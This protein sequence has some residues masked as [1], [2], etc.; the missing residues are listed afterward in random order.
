MSLRLQAEQV[1]RAPRDAVWAALT[2]V[3]RF[4]AAA[5]AR[6][7]GLARRPPGPVREGTRWSGTFGVA[8]RPRRVEAVLERM[9]PESG[10]RLSADA[11]GMAVTLQ[12]VPS[13]A[14]AGVRLAV[15]TEA[16]A[17]T[18]GGRLALKAAELG[19][20]RMQRT[21]E[22]RLAAFARRVEAGAA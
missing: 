6:D 8:G 19:R 16:R 20:D 13:D 7:P 12:A 18:F 5:R 17:T 9:D 4:E 15:A 14:P 1:V 2:D 22:E 3:A 10:L 11:D 21:L